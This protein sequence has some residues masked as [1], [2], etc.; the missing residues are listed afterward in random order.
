MNLKYYAH[1]T[2]DKKEN[3]IDHLYSTADLA[4]DFG[5]DFESEKICRQLGLL[6]DIG[7][8]TESFQQ[9][10]NGEKHLQDHAIVSAMFYFKYGLCPDRW[11]KK[12]LALI[13]GC[14]HS[15]LYTSKQ[16]ID[17]V[18]LDSRI[19]DNKYI[20]QTMDRNKEIAVRDMEE[21]EKIKQYIKDNH[22]L[23][24]L[25]RSDFLN[26]DA[27]TYNERML[28][29]RMLYSCVV[30]AD[31]SATADFENPGYVKKYL[32]TNKFNAASLLNKL[33]KYHNR[34][35]QNAEDS[36]IN[37]MRSQVYDACAKKG[38]TAEGFFTL[39]APT[40][41]GKTLA[42]IKFALEQAKTFNKKRI[43]IVLP[44]LSVIDQNAS[45]YKEIFGDDVVLVDNSQTEFSDEMR[46]YSDRWSSPIIVTTSVKFF[47][48]LFASKATDVRRLHNVCKSVVVFDEC[49]TL[50]GYLLNTTLEVMQA[51][52]KYYHTTVLFSTATQP[53]YQYRNQIS[54]EKVCN[55]VALRL[56]R[57]VS[58]DIAVIAKMEWQADEII[59]D[60][61]DLFKQYKKIKNTEIACETEKEMD[62]KGLVDYYA[63][64][65]AA[66]YI[67]NTVKKAVDMYQQVVDTYGEDGCY[68]LTSRFNAKDKE[69]IIEQIR[70]R[71]DN[72]Q[73]IRVIATQCIEAGVD[74]DFPC[75]AREFG[76]LDSVI[77]AA[78]RINRNGK[79]DGKYLVFKH[80]NHDVKRDYPSAS[81]QEA[82]DI[83]ERLARKL[84]GLD[85][86]D[87]Q[88]LDAYY[89]NLYNYSVN[90][91]KDDPNLTSS[92]SSDS[93]GELDENYEIIKNNDQM[94]M[95]T[96]PFFT[97]DAFFEDCKKEIEENGFIITKKMMKKLSKY[98]VSIYK[99]R[100][101]SGDKFGIC[102]NMKK[103]NDL[104]R[105]NWFLVEDSTFY[106]K[107]GFDTNG[108]TDAG[109][110]L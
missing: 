100:K 99:N 23:L 95:V 87:P 102:M 81:Y 109:W 89:D 9:V 75:G 11:L 24:K 77:Q 94:I 90:H 26:I 44:F 64:E 84:N 68:I 66:L 60:V 12:H 53:C 91:T 108:N 40:G 55:R 61:N 73:F 14:H 30:D 57:K 34:L 13:M 56:K 37:R 93:Y 2:S 62:S 29:I 86:Y 3:L 96:A 71:L 28:Y 43:I 42:L 33:N 32:H 25:K 92:I 88:V 10:L 50:P 17:C 105:T 46:I 19:E 58:E 41:T 103:G 1:K 35:C 49:Q 82:S 27:M 38:A 80:V 98:T 15:F 47:E 36:D 110:V 70:Q 21:Y 52:V 59:D 69:Y 83:T 79:Y 76:P 22:L 85:L 31:Y 101:V 45:I 107:L 20:R 8:L 104:Y 7:K 67:F 4:E 97:E 5:T 6:H 72:G 54:T 16:D 74:F 39:N 48:T 78:G 106:G 63:D 51:L 65:R 18:F